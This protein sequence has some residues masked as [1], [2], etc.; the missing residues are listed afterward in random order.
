MTALFGGSKSQHALHR[1]NHEIIMRI[2]CVE[3]VPQ[4]DGILL[5]LER[6]IQWT[7]FVL[8]VPLPDRRAIH[9][10][11][12]N[13]F[14][15]LHE[16]TLGQRKNLALMRVQN[17]NDVCPNRTDNCYRFVLELSNIAMTLRSS[18]W[19]ANA[20]TSCSE[21][22]HH[23]NEGEGDMAQ[24]L[25]QGIMMCRSN[26]TDIGWYPA[27]LFNYNNTQCQS[28]HKG[29]PIALLIGAYEYIQDIIGK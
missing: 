17:N 18:K 24:P 3:I 25:D 10:Q 23:V 28:F 12:P 16:N 9:H 4:S 6:P 7:H 13:C 8:P 15:V 22:G 1:S 21:F 19:L 14:A 29:F 20:N 27:G 2:D 5:H 26:R 11:E